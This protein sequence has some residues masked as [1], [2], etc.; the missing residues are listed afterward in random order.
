LLYISRIWLFYTL[1]L[2]LS[3]HLLEV[4]VHTFVD[5]DPVWL[6]LAFTPSTSIETL[7]KSDLSVKLAISRLA[8][9]PHSRIVLSR[10]RILA[11]KVGWFQ[12][13][14]CD[15]LIRPL[16]NGVVFFLVQDRWLPCY[17]LRLNVV[18]SW[19]LSMLNRIFLDQNNL[20]LLWVSPMFAQIVETL[21]INITN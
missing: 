15:L 17:E 16:S 20:L 13:R 6:F 7:M 3:S 11:L 18:L 1:N 5:F 2:K 9:F 21:V 19:G 14:K 8:S 12:I 4:R 10:L